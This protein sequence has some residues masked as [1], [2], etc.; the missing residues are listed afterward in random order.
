MCTFVC[1]HTHQGAGCDTSSIFK[2]S[3]TDLNSEFSFFLVDCHA[4]VKEPRLANGLPIVG[5]R[6]IIL[7]PRVPC[8]MQT[9]KSWI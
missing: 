9:A 5:G 1:V 8:R 2:Q 6:I 7:F 3:L 4:M